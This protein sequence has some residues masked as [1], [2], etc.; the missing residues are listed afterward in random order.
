[1]IEQSFKNGFYFDTIFPISYI[2]KWIRN[3]VIYHKIVERFA[4][5]L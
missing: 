2:L 3:R 5:Q 1:M 4:I